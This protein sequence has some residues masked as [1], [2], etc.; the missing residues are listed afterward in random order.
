MFCLPYKELSRRLSTA[1]KEICFDQYNRK[2]GINKW[3]AK[4]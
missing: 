3:R 4:A 1:E 2:P